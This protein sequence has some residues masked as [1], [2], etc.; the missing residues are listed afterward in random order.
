MGFLKIG[1]ISSKMVILTTHPIIQSMLVEILF[2]GFRGC[3]KW[4]RIGP[5]VYVQGIWG[6]HGHL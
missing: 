1:R 5:T 4:E 6:R 2:S 3:K